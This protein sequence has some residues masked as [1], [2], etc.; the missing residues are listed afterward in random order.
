VRTLDSNIATS[1]AFTAALLIFPSAHPI[2]DATVDKQPVK[3][4]EGIFDSWVVLPESA[5]QPVPLVPRLVRDIRL[6]TGWSQRG[7]A[8]VLAST[9]P[10]IRALEEGRSAAR[11]ND[12]YDRLLEAHEVIERVFLVAG[13]DVAE[14]DRMLSSSPSEERSPASELLE[15]RQPAQAYLAALD[16]RRPRRQTPMMVGQWPIRAGEA[17]TALSETDRD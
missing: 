3:A 14:T 2:A 15:A 10:T 5:A 6:W 7:L 8:K 9:H 11:T 1:A 13:R 17:T 16:V 12:L 4:T